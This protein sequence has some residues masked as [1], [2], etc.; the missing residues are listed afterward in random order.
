MVYQSFIQK[1]ELNTYY[2]PG[3]VLVNYKNEQDILIVL[4][5]LIHN[6]R[7]RLG[8]TSLVFYSYTTITLINSSATKCLGLCPH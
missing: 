7:E 2:M 6:L 5:D 4:E 1:S 8:K 3:T